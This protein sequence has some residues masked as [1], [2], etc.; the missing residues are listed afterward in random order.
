MS[1]DHP[2][3]LVQKTKIWNPVEEIWEDSV[4]VPCGKCLPCKKKRVNQW[5][6]RLMQ[7]QKKSYSSYFVTL[8]YNTDFVP[9][10]QRGKMTLVKTT[11]QSDKLA[12][13]QYSEKLER[14]K[15]G[16]KTIKYFKSGA[17]NYDISAQAFIKRLRYYQEE[18]SKNGKIDL[19]QFRRARNTTSGL[20]TENKIKYYL[21]GEYGS[22]RFRPH[23]HIILFNVMSCDDIRSAWTYGTVWIDDVNQN[24]V[25]YTLKYI[26]KP[27]EQKPK[28]FD[29]IPEF[30]LMSKGLGKNYLTHD[31]AN[32]HKKEYNNFVSNGKGVKI[33]TPRYYT[34]KILSK[35]NKE[36]KAV[37]NHNETLRRKEEEER[38]GKK[39]GYNPEEIRIKIAHAN[40]HKLKSPIKDRGND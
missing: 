33:P 19:E 22:K 15:V 38:M 20:Y 21:A 18:R 2:L 35:E 9:L 6:F 1:C 26:C 31:T 34:Q 32:F 39:Y 23:L 11:E 14:K 29:G 37:W 30:S 16:T 27:P 17:E 13:L 4:R 25:D 10:T 12:E 24:T 5:S 36:I 7:E 40:T 8:T 3:T 28:G